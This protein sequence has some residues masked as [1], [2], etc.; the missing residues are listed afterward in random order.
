MRISLLQH[1]MLVTLFLTNG[2][3]KIA[4]KRGQ[5]FESVT[6][7]CYLYCCT[8]IRIRIGA[9]VARLVVHRFTVE[10]SAR[11]HG[12]LETFPAS[13]CSTKSCKSLGSG[14]WSATVGRVS[15]PLKYYTKFVCLVVVPCSMIN[16]CTI[17][18]YYGLTPTFPPQVVF[19]EES[20]SW[21]NSPTSWS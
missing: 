6:V 12:S 15:L 3:Y 10:A 16:P 5:N 11:G 7:S 19:H 1:Q 21:C 9:A 18:I 17:L 20:S 4:A 8:L 2:K 14:H 13:R